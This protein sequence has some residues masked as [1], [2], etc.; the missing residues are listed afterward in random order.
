MK[1]GFY[2]LIVRVDGVET[3]AFARVAAGFFEGLGILSHV[4][5]YFRPGDVSLPLGAVPIEDLVPVGGSRADP[6]R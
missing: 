5:G 1:D 3:E 4:R 2:R 6:G